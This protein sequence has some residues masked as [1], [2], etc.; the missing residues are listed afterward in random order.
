[1]LERATGCLE[2][3]GRHFLRTSS[4]LCRSRRALRSS[5]WH[6]GAGDLDLPSWWATILHPPIGPYAEGQYEPEGKATRLKSA[7]DLVTD[8]PILDFLYPTHTLA[9]I[10]R[11]SRLGLERWERCHAHRLGYSSARG[12]SSKSGGVPLAGISRQEEHENDGAIRIVEQ[13]DAVNI[14]SGSTEGPQ[15]TRL[16]GIQEAKHALSSLRPPLREDSNLHSLRLL[17]RSSSKRDQEEAWKLYTGLAE[18]RWQ[19]PALKADL[20]EY[21][22]ASRRKED[23]ERSLTIYRTLQTDERRPSSY[24]AAVAAFLLLQQSGK[25]VMVHEEACVKG[26]TDG[27]G[28]ELLLPYMISHEQWQLAIHVYDAFSQMLRREEV[29]GRPRAWR[30]AQRAHF[31]SRVQLLPELAEKALSLTK[32]ANQYLKI[33]SAETAVSRKF[34]SKL[35]G[36][37]IRH[38][39]TVAKGLPERRSPGQR[40]QIRALFESMEE[41]QIPT[42]NLLEATLLQ[43]LRSEEDARYS[44]HQPLVKFLYLR[45]RDQRTINQSKDVIF[46]MLRRLCKHEAVDSAGPLSVRSV[47]GRL[48]VESVTADWLRIH[49]RPTQTMLTLLMSTYARLGMSEKVYEYFT[50]LHTLYPDFP[51]EDS[52]APFVSLIYVHARR[53]EILQAV[54]QFQRIGEQFGLT[55]NV[56]CWNALIHAYARVDDMDGG[57]RCFNAMREADVRPTMYTFGPLLDLCARRG[58]TDGVNNLLSLARLAQVTPSTHMLN[59]AVIACVNNEDLEAAEEIAEKVVEESKASK[60]VGSLTLVWNSMLTAYALR[61]DV[62][63]TRRIYRKMQTLDVPLDSMS[64][65]AL[66]QALV[67]CRQTDAAA[68]IMKELMPD[69]GVRVLAIHYAILMA[70][71]IKQ[72]LYEKVVKLRHRMEK[73]NI[74]STLATNIS[75]LKAKTIQELKGLRGADFTDRSARLFNAE[76]ELVKMVDSADA[77]E[78]AAKQPQL[79]ISRMPINESYPEA[80]FEFMIFVYGRKKSFNVVK[81]LHAKYLKLKQQTTGELPDTRPPMR[82]LT[83]LM[84]SYFHAREYSEVLKCWDFLRTQAAAYA[85]LWNSNPSSAFAPTSIDRIAAARR[86]VLAR[87][88]FIYM[89]ALAKLDDTARIQS[90]IRELLASGYVLD[91]RCWNAYVR[92]LVRSS[93]IVQAFHVCE[94]HLIGDWPGWV[95]LP[96]L[97]KRHAVKNRTAY[98]AAPRNPLPNEL[99]PAYSTMVYL[100]AAVLGLKRVEALGGG[101]GETV[102][103]IRQVAP[104]TLSAV[105]QMPRVDD[106]FQMMLL[107]T[108]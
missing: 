75:Y 73:R 77:T 93:R 79:G 17:L 100:A 61:R 60:I 88:F 42:A 31:W 40:S 94:T 28:S 70:G 64:Y 48:T 3:G 67:L 51:D 97:P 2:S 101:T 85:A 10:R 43:L 72:G 98:I 62:A 86:Y 37:A 81:Q 54:Q 30:V 44:N 102:K 66:M 13:P 1:M 34:I 99:L 8:E 47:T 92:I 36:R 74:R 80:Y 19:S 96:R 41:L 76:E 89:S 22:S 78:I 53:A 68:K 25:A 108:L 104:R 49:G 106:P 95:Q 7:S 107:R 9:L 26:I 20:L 52:L 82:L 55:P 56:A 103:A 32:L 27:V 63:D 87:P 5:F 35:A 90:T 91:S 23:A 29:R 50:Q 4:R 11:I 71:Y 38:T 21:L 59:C 16:D 33:A 12:Y 46:G 84:S 15:P 45:Y 69:N 83:A 65:A 58:D 24:R 18:K 105:E 57:L 39:V 14:T 6:H